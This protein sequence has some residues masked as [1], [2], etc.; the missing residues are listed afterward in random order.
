MKN[1]QV[2]TTIFAL[3]LTFSLLYS[4]D[5]L[6][7]NL[8]L[9]SFQGGEYFPENDQMNYQ[10]KTDFR[11]GTNLSL[12]EISDLSFRLRYT[13]DF[14]EEK[15][16]LD[17]LSVN[18]YSQNSVFAFQVYDRKYGSKSILQNL[19]A[20]RGHFK[21][22]LLENYRFVGLSGIYEKQFNDSNYL[23]LN[24]KI[25]G[26]DFNRTLCMLDLLYQDEYLDFAIGGIYSGRSNRNNLTGILYYSEL[27]YE[28]SWWKLYTVGSTE[29]LENDSTDPTISRQKF[30]GESI[31]KI[32]SFFSLGGGLYYEKE[33][34]DYDQYDFTKHSTFIYAEPRYKNFSNSILL[35]FS[36]SE[37][38]E[39][40]KYQNILNY[41]ITDFWKLGLN[42]SYID[43]NP[44][45]ENYQIG[46]QVE[47]DYESL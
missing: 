43:P 5:N 4:V 36:D 1:I 13:H 3:L 11:I 14:F 25:G 37:N 29:Y 19:D 2:I 22:G 31:F 32:A 42:T 12:T 8:E 18:L 24:G 6:N 46:F 7:F 21:Q 9:D 26:N 40:N 28:L 39:Y 47:I 20:S 17:S 16:M 34:S 45:T 15:I 27:K 10:H 41:A 30:Y 23:S 38:Y 44:G 33:D 35:E